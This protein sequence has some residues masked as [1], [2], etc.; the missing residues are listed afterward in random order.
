MQKSGNT[1]KITR[2]VLILLTVLLLTAGCN[3]DKSNVVFILVDQ[4]RGSATGYAGDPNVK[5]PHLDKFASEAITF[6]NAVSV[7]PVCTPY[8]AS[9]LSGRYPTTTG[10]FLNDAYLPAEELCLSEVFKDNGYN[11]GYIG[12]WHL[13]G[14]GR[15]DFTP[16]ERRQG[17]DYW[18]A[19]ECSHDYNHM[20][21]YE[22]DSPEIKYW[23]GYSPFAVAKD[24]QEYITSQASQDV[25]FFLLVSIAAPHFP[26]QT[27]PEEFKNLYSESDIRLNPNVPET[28]H[29]QARKELVGY[30]AH[31]SATDQAIGGI[32]NKIKELDMMKNTILVFTSDHGEIMGAQGIRIKQ[33]QVPWNEAASVPLIVSFPSSK[34]IKNRTI[35]MP[36]TTPDI[37]SSLLSLAGLTIPESFEGEDFADI[38]QGQKELPDHGSLYM[39]VAPFASVRKEVKREYRALKTSQY[40]YVK[41]LDGPWLLYDDL[42]DPYQMNNLV[43]DPDFAGILSDL[44]E[45]LMA[46]L[47]RNK[48]D[49]QPAEYYIS[50]WG[51]S[52]TKNGH[53]PYQSYKQDPQSPKR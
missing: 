13:D 49:F 48:D 27:A 26:H 22:G 4:W 11:T 20:A 15:F 35:T 28:L 30:Y 37:S 36:I 1:I 10:M 25:P 14:Q 40:T 51:F 9:L 41:S 16:P 46:E 52:V 21:Y 44:D 47:R 6:K 32:L 5:T 43:S 38:I 8:R 33:K 42:A 2:S 17:F 18:K 34:G 53:I 31:C 24:A 50:K 45:Q 7:C 39:S 19:L 29:E 12:K 3:H 23:E